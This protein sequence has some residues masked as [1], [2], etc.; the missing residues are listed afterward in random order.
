M[1]LATL[2]NGTR[3][4]ALAVV[5]RDLAT[6][7]PAREVVAGLETLQ[8]ALDDWDTYADKLER[9]SGSQIFVY[10]STSNQI[11]QALEKNVPVNGKSQDGKGAKP[12]AGKPAVPGAVP[13]QPPAPPRK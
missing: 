10:V 5:S 4:G 3:D 8:Q 6:A 11:L 9:V 1:K 12:V 2:R 13:G 7:V